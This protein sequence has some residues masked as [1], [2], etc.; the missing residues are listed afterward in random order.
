MSDRLVDRP[1]ARCRTLAPDRPLNIRIPPDPYSGEGP[2]LIMSYGSP[3]GN[4]FSRPNRAGVFIRRWS[5]NDEVLPH[6]MCAAHALASPLLVGDRRRG[7][8]DLGPAAS[9]ARD[10][11]VRACALPGT[12]SPA[13]VSRGLSRSALLAA[14]KAAAEMRSG[15]RGSTV[16][17]V[18]GGT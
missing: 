13:I 7:Q 11:E 10:C 5:P 16:G 1:R 6:M 9:V 3:R 4:W 2:I 18:P 17:D 8:R 14:V 12:R 15:R